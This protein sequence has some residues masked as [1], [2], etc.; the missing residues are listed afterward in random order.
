MSVETEKGD[1]EQQSQHIFIS[2]VVI[3]KVTCENFKG[4]HNA[5]ITNTPCKYYRIS[6]LSRSSACVFLAV[7]KLI[8]DEIQ[9]IFLIA[10][11]S[12]FLKYTLN[13]LD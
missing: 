3:A 10:K 2:S 11:H 4:R 13:K 5:K 12:G 9:N 7:N 6:T 1:V 8:T